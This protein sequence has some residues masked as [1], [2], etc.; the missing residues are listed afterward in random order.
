MKPALQAVVA[1]IRAG[2]T[3]TV[4]EYGSLLREAG[5]D[6]AEA[7][8]LVTSYRNAIAT[9]AEEELMALLQSFTLARNT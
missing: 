8:G 9:D 7:R 4:L 5:C 1:K 2:E 6:Q 3:P